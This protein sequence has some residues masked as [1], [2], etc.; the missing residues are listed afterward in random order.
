MRRRGRTI[1][2]TVRHAHSIKKGVRIRNRSQRSSPSRRGTPGVTT[3]KMLGTNIATAI[4]VAMMAYGH[5]KDFTVTCVM[6][7]PPERRYP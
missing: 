3:I 2:T 6:P 1:G 7:S 4:I 5:L